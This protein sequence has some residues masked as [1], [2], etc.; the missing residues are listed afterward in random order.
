MHHVV[1]A[2]LV[3]AGRVLLTRRA[4]TRSA[5]P[6]RW[7][8]PGGH[9]EDGEPEVRALRRELREELGIAV[10]A[11]AVQPLARLHVPADRP[12][13]G[14]SLSTWRVR[15]W[16]GTPVNL[17][18]DEH[19]ALAWLGARELDALPLAHDEQRELLRALLRG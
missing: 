18:P 19:E 16:R 10:S 14:L 8:L 4:R 6:G 13:E 12:G 5:H 11:R 3:S 15:R 2:A 7:A 1:T 17:R 9:V